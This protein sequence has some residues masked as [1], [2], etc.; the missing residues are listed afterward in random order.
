MTPGD[1]ARELSAG[2]QSDLGMTYDATR[3]GQWRRGGRAI[4]SRCRIGCCGR[5][6][7]ML[8]ASAG[9]FR[10]PPMPTLTGLRRCFAR[11]P[12]S[13][14]RVKH[15]PPRLRR[16]QRPVRPALGRAG[17]LDVDFAGLKFSMLARH[18]ASIFPAGS[19]RSTARASL[20][21]LFGAPWLQHC[22]RKPPNCWPDT[23]LWVLG[24]SQKTMPSLIARADSLTTDC[25]SRPA[26]L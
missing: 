8:S 15:P 19:N 10:H 23:R 26:F 17:V 9:E 5:A 13:P 7:P 3:I 21:E 11:R 6:L 14:L 18:H 20:C 25:I 16:A 1:A 24:L 2:L 22:G 12:G 4:R